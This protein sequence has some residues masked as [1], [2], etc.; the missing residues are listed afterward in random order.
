V[1]IILQ[2]KV[3]V[4]LELNRYFEQQRLKKKLYGFFQD[5]FIQVVVDCVKPLRT[6]RVQAHGDIRVRRVW[7]QVAKVNLKQRK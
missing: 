3:L 7:K 2:K 1:K 5:V 6:S 4:I